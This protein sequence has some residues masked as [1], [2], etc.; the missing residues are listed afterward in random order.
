MDEEA[1]DVLVNIASNISLRY[2]LQLITTSAIVAS[3]RRS[4]TVEAIDIRFVQS[5][6]SDVNASSNLL[7]SMEKYWMQDYSSSTIDDED[8]EAEETTTSHTDA[9]ASSSIQTVTTTVTTTT[10]PPP[11]TSSKPK[12]TIV[13]MDLDED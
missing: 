4:S 12:Q 9:P 7:D 13:E 11:T 10:A 8:E 6:F 5:R 2:A 3:N 1:K